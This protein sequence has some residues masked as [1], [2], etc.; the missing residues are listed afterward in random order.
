MG[1]KTPVGSPSANSEVGR[2]SVMSGGTTSGQTVTSQTSASSAGVVM[3]RRQVEELARWLDEKLAGLCIPEEGI[4][5][6]NLGRAGGE[7]LEMR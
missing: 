5:L 6:E 7:Q 4:G 3:M 1:G 2:A